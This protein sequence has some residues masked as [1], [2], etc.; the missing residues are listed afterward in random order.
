[1]IK[2]QD[3]L[4]YARSMMGTPFHHQGRLPKVGLDCVGLLVVVARKFN[5]TFHDLEGYSR[6]PDGVTLERELTKCLDRIEIAEVQPGDILTFWMRKTTQIQHAGIATEHG[7]I[8][9]WR[10][11]RGVV[12][13][14]LDNDWRLQLAGAYRYRGVEDVP[15]PKKFPWE[16]PID[17]K[18]LEE[19]RRGTPPEGC[20]G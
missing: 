15:Y 16:P 5:L 11:S 12:E 6:L 18:V 8:H 9:T 2:R 14:G 13:H 4:D 1:M 10:M 17:P 20:C 7:M 19:V 3:I